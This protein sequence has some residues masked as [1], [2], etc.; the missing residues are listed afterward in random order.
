MP[1]RD[2]PAIGTPALD[3]EAAFRAPHVGRNSA[4]ALVGSLLLHG[5][6][7]LVL[8]QAKTPPLALDERD[9]V[10]VDV[11]Q[12]SP[13]VPEPAVVPPA[14]TQPPPKAVIPPRPRSEPPPPTPDEP[15]PPAAETPV[16]FANLTLTNQG[17]SSFAVTPSS[18]VE[19]E[20]PL[21]PAGVNTGQRRDGVVGGTPGGTGDLDAKVVPVADLGRP[22]KMPVGLDALIERFYPRAARAQAIEGKARVRLRIDAN[23][24]ARILSVAD[25]GT[26]GF[27]DS[28][29]QVLRAAPRWEPPVD[30]NGRPVATEINFT[31]NFEVRR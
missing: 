25:D 1:A 30:R 5:S 27:G 11:V 17:K 18:G 24:S 8:A 20:G 2:A 16:D 14:A 10:T 29:R 4:L 3:S 6:V 15:P 31:C 13:P 12:E 21:G 19:Q 9:N 26:H 22:P 7:L 28:C 23:G